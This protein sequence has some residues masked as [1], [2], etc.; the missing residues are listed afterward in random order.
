[1]LEKREQEIIRAD[2]REKNSLVISELISLK[3]NLKLENLKVAD[4]IINNLAIERKSI[5]DFLSSILNKRLSRQLQELKQYPKRLLIIEGMDEQNLYE[6]KQKGIHA[7]AI[8]GFLLSILLE[9]KVPVIFTKDYRDTAKF[10][11]LL[12]KKKKKK[13][14]SIR[15]VKKILGKKQQLQFILEGFPKIGPVKA[16]RLLEKFKTLKNVINAPLEELSVI[17]GK[18]ASIFKSLVDSP[19]L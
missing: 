16:K 7:N 14:I 5:S 10:L 6:D 9:H 2:I 15:P 8:R 13:E 1:M 19:H 11:Y 17:L 3:I 18:S 12:A 4:Y